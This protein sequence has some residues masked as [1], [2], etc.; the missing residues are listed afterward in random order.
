M[1]FL[2]RSYLI[3]FIAGL[4]EN[5]LSSL[6]LECR[7]PEFH[8]HPWPWPGLPEQAVPEGFYLIMTLMLTR[9]DCQLPEERLLGTGSALTGGFLPSM[10]SDMGFL[11]SATL[12]ELGLGLKTHV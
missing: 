11:T 4:R 12:C 5:I 3:P 6:R 2:N 7:K 9:L 10:Q 8:L 1:T